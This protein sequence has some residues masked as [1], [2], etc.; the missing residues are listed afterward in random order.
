MKVVCVDIG[1]SNISFG[2]YSVLGSGEAE[3]IFRVSSDISRTEDEYAVSLFSLFEV[4]SVSKKDVVGFCIS[5]VVPPLQG[6]FERMVKKFFGDV[7]LVILG[8]G[9][10]TGIAVVYNPPS[11]VGADRIANAV[12]AWEKYGKSSKD[13]KPIV[14]VDFGTAITFDCISSSGEYVG[15]AIFPGI[16]LAVESLFKRTAKLPSIK[17]SEP[18]G[19]IGKSTTHS[20]QSGIIYGYASMID[21]MIEKIENEFGERV[22]SVA[23]GGN[24]E[25][26]SHHTSRIEKIDKTLTLDGLFFIFKK[27][28]KL[29]NP[30]NTSKR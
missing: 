7:P 13:R 2:V 20:I 12:G 1:N 15:G 4:F 6:T 22:F 14:V 17:I 28:V 25:I 19:V 9:T 30:K 26:V 18:A 21:G 16:E 27:N 11:D 8:P 29:R 10:K 5:S 24:A 3:A 23:T